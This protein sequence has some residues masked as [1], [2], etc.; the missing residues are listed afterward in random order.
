MY[1][2]YGHTGYLKFKQKHQQYGPCFQTI[3]PFLDLIQMEYHLLS[4][5]L[6]RADFL[7]TVETDK[8]Y[9]LPGTSAIF[10]KS[11]IRE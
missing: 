7:C 3:F 5:I 2:L 10:H 1:A 11:I 9:V 8:S 6:L 4:R